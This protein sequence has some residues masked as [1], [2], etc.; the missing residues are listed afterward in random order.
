MEFKYAT[1]AVI[2]GFK[3]LPKGEGKIKITATRYDKEPHMVVKHYLNLYTA[4]ALAYEILH[5]SFKDTFP[6]GFT[7]YKGSLLPDGTVEARVLKIEHKSAG[8]FPY[9]VTISN[10]EGEKMTTGAVKMKKVEREVMFPM[11]YLDAKRLS[12]Y[13]LEVGTWLEKHT[14]SEE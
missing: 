6:N 8:K 2:C 10:G 13:L 14:S 5:N 1:N 3:L 12:V 11:S 7:D 9:I 4:K